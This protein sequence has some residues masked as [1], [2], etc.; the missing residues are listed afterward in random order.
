MKRLV[1]ITVAVVFAAVALLIGLGSLS[2]PPVPLAIVAGSENKTLEPLML[3]WAK[4]NNVALTVTYLG[5]VDIARELEKGTAGAYD[6]VWPAHSLW[7]ALGDTQKVVKHSESILRSP[8]VLGLKKSIAE[9]LGW[10]NRQDITVQMIAEAATSKQFRLAMTSATQSNSGA[11]A[12]FGFLYAL[13]GSPD[14]LTMDDLNDLAV[15]DAVRKL[16]AQVDRSSG[17]SGWLGES[18]VANPEAYDAMVNYES[19]VLEANQA[20]STTGQDPLYIIYPANGLSV[21]DSP[22]A[23]VAKGD[24]AKE[25]AFLKLQEFLLSSDTQK[26]LSDLGR[27]SGLIGMEAQGADPQI[28]RADWGA[29]LARE[30]APVPTPGADVI[31]EALSLYQTELRKPS[32][33]V[34][35]LDVSGSMTGEPLAKLKQAMA[36]LLDK[37]A[38][39]VNLLQPSRRDVTIIIPFNDRV[40]QPIIVKGSDDA[41]LAAALA[42][43][44]ALEAGGGTDLYAALGTA[45]QTLQPF[46]DDGTLFTYLPAIVAMT[47]GASDLVNFEYFT[48]VRNRI[49]F[50][51][52]IPI[53][54]VAFGQ[55]DMKQLTALTTQ[56]IGR[57]FTAANDLAGALRQAKGYN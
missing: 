30:I 39:A 51:N 50:G 56:S 15:Q 45:L 18:L 54:A 5:S 29:D 12:Y 35:V 28:W 57:L 20:L 11:S 48:Q 9:K 37:Q 47:D 6:A 23:F 17:S 16:L 40:G 33:T 10:T 7:I 42:Q 13:A 24:A 36:L 4:K 53:H 46:K 22:L 27:R 19:T 31:A 2:G 38:A 44:N 43:V 34:W 14:I 3:D 41:A 8:V 32:L 26:S 55:P 49:G 52:D 21:A 25:A 1:T